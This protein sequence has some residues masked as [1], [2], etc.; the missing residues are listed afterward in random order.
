MLRLKYAGVILA[1]SDG[2]V[3]AQRRDDNPKIQNPGKWGICGG[4]YEGQIDNDIKD[5]AV[6]ELWEE[7]GYLVNRSDL[8]FVGA[9]T[10]QLD[11]GAVE[12]EDQVFWAPHDGVQEIRLLGEGQEIR[13]ISPQE[14]SILPIA[15]QHRPFLLEVSGYFL[16]RDIE[17]GS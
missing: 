13:F 5:T 12:I 15:E 16:R 9:T 2:S 14:C 8:R 1:K 17:R 11:G 3:L 7:T 6:R 4:G 10:K